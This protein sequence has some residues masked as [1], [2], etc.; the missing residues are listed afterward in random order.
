MK[1]KS[2]V[3]ISTTD[4]LGGAAIAANRL[5][6]AMLKS[7]LHSAMLVARK[8]SVDNSICQISRFDSF[9]RYLYKAINS[10]VMKLFRTMQGYST[11]DFFGVN[12]DKYIASYDILYIHYTNDGFL[13]YSGISRLISTYPNK[14]IILVLH[15]MC[16]LTG[17]CH[18]SFECNKYANEGCSTCP[19]LKLHFK[20]DI[21]KII[22]ECKK[23]LF[24]N[25][26]DN[27]TILSPS[28]WMSLN[29]F[30]SRLFKETNKY[31]IA[32]CIDTECFTPLPQTSARS[33][34][35]LPQSER[36]ILFG[37]MAA[38]TNPYKGWSFLVQAL[39]NIDE[40]VCVLIFGV[41]DISVL[42]SQINQK[43]YS[44]G[45]LT[46]DKELCYA[47]NAADLFVSPSLADNL[48]STIIESMSCETPVVGFNIGGIPDI[49]IHKN[50]GYLAKY[51]DVSDLVEG[52]NYTLENNKNNKL[53]INA[54]KSILMKFSEHIIVE[55]HKNQ[56]INE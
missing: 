9:R 27:L 23:K 32:N 54:R 49:I 31:T 40:N 24:A 42:A 39:R 15:D 10:A 13:S 44:L 16:Y 2:I 34:F 19:N 28:N 17:S 48:P 11:V 29:V 25:N 35:N 8:S 36:Y 38:L 56:I 18:H 46:S 53:G 41:N 5:H 55:M 21:S 51:K 4:C 6:Q 26:A 22:F 14:K 37:A 7:D 30:N 47:Y 12:I 52:I 45:I 43:I 3:H 50:N 20:Y 1:S 33:F